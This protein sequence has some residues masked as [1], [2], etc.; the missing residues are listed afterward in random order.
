MDIYEIT[1][2]NN[3]QFILH[4]EESDFINNLVSTEKELPMLNWQ[5]PTWCLFNKTKKDVKKRLDFNA[6]C[7]F[8]GTLIL[9]KNIAKQ[10]VNHFNLKAQ[11]LPII[12]PEL[13]KEFVFC[14]IINSIPAIPNPRDSDKIGKFAFSK[15]CIN[16]NIIFRD[17]FYLYQYFC[18][19][20]F[21]DYTI[22]N[23]ILGLDFK[24]YGEAT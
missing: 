23:C 12:T 1:Q 11:L 17:S 22:K 6:S 16:K 5:A 19:D 7:F 13:E 2:D 9:E 4:K 15:N 10:M 8:S 3:F 24:K 20:K 18:T 14:N 21:I